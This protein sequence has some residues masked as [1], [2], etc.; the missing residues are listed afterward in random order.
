MLVHHRYSAA[1]AGAALGLDAQEVIDATRRLGIDP[2]RRPRRPADAPLLVL[3]YPGGRHPR[4]G[5]RD[6]MIRPQREATVS[7][8]APWPD[9][10]YAVAN[11]PEAVWFQP[12]DRPALLYLAHTH[13]PTT[14]AK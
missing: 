4:L 14:W 6:G 3:P 9:G 8:F 12:N 5:F 10:G 7:V 13:V 11:V 1:E 2:A